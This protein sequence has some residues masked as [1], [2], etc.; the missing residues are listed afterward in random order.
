[1]DIFE[2]INEQQAVIDKVDESG[3]RNITKLA[4]QYK[5]AT[6][7][8][9]MDTDGV[10]SAIAMRVYLERY[11]IKTIKVIP[12]NYGTSEFKADVPLTGTLNWMVRNDTLCSRINLPE[13]SL[14]RRQPFS[15]LPFSA[16]LCRRRD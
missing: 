12:I 6:G 4:K 14:F 13:F 1:M 8:F 15:R 5:K 7:Y 9:H 11:G 10:T 16:C 2:R 3:I